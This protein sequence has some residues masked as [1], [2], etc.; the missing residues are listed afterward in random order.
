MTELQ[1]LALSGHGFTD[2][3]LA[4]LAGLTKLR[5]LRLF[6]TAVTTNG[7]AALKTRLPQCEVEV[8]GR[9]AHD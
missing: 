2:A 1:E 7:V 5:N 9:D 8:W 3:G 6:E 4:G